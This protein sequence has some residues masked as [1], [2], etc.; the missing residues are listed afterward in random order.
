V[1]HRNHSLAEAEGARHQ[2]DLDQQPQQLRVVGQ[3]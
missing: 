2:V 3:V 1:R